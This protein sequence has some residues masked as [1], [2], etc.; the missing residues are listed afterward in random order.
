MLEKLERIDSP[1]DVWARA[2]RVRFRFAEAPRS[3][4]IVLDCSGLEARRGGA[5]GEDTD[6]LGR[7]AGRPGSVDQCRHVGAAAGNEDSDLGFAHSA[8]LPRKVT[9]SP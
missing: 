4:D 7:I 6:D 5:I 1:E 2:E 9:G 8:S 3:G